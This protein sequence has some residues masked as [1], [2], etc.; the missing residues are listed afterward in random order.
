M[1][2]LLSRRV[3]PDATAFRR[4]RWGRRFRCLASGAGIS[5]Y[6][7]G[8]GLFSI[9]G[10]SRHVEDGTETRDLRLATTTGTV[11]SGLLSQLLPAFQCEHGIQVSVLARGTEAAL[12]LARE[13]KADVLIVHARE[14]ED[15]FIVEGYGVNRLDVM[16]DD[17]ILL[18]PPDDP[19]R[20]RGLADVL[21]AMK[22][23]SDRQAPFLSRGDRSGTHLREL[24]LW[25][26][27]GI[28]PSDGWL[29]ESGQNMLE[30]LRMAS[31]MDAY[32]LSDRST[33]LH[34]HQELDL[35]VCVEGDRRLF[36]PYTVIAVNPAKVSGVDFRAA[37]EFVDFLTSIEGQEI[38]ASYGTDRFG[39]PLFTPLVT[40]D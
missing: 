31:D 37:M 9:C 19:A 21:V 5:L 26:L 35:S 28:E 6:F 17:I 8:L 7:A 29:R 20:I 39:E 36:N 13:G 33:Y 11:G 3:A 10:C 2:W 34:N 4:S 14:A 24:R 15:A 1:I 30:T 40:V 22:S 25:S 18:G 12:D 16:H 23:I 32:V 27:A 38:I